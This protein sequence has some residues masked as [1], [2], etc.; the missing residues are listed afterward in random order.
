MATAAIPAVR[1]SPPASFDD[2]Q[3]THYVSSSPPTFLAS[4]QP[5]SSPLLS[6][7]TMSPPAREGDLI[8]PVHAL[9][10]PAGKQSP[11]QEVHIVKVT[12]DTVQLERGPIQESVLHK[13]GASLAHG[14]PTFHP[15]QREGSTDSNV[16]PPPPS[17]PSSV[18]GDELP[19]PRRPVAS[20]SHSDSST[21]PVTFEEPLQRTSSASRERSS[22]ALRHRS[23]AET[24]SS[25]R[26]SQSGY[27]SEAGPTDEP[28]A[29]LPPSLS[30]SL[31]SRAG[32]HV[33]VDGYLHPPVPHKPS[34]R[35]TIGTSAPVPAQSPPR[36]TR[37]ATLQSSHPTAFE[38]SGELAD[39]IEL[40]AEQIRRE[41][42]S[43]RFKQ[44]QE[45][46][47]AL[48]RSATVLSRV[49]DKPLVGNLIGED[50]VNYV[51]MYN[52]LTG[53]RIAVSTAPSLYL[54]HT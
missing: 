50:H 7:P 38:E 20:S 41:R 22:R 10:F 16:G 3:R 9:A 5:R 37:M 47:R 54:Q 19:A 36:V 4:P 33:S 44:Q 32:Q 40:Q 6:T 45:A 53:I 35:N 27:T 14:V 52:M 25:L 31:P 43:K 15:H 48:T 49:D 51:L 28:P 23:S 13:V 17:P 34:R 46:E 39:D 8:N 21:R 30:K 11:A 18:E 42:M 1:T 24:K 29:N 26:T 2:P 12:N